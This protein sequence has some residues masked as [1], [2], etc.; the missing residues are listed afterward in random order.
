MGNSFSKL[1]KQARQIESQYNQ[2][3]ETLKA[4]EVVGVA[5]GGL[6]QITL[7]GDHAFKKIVIQPACVDANDIEGLQDLIQAAYMDAHHKLSDQ[8]THMLPGMPFGI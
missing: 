6:V 7:S 2:M 8:A 4:Q 1:K 5:G 3:Q